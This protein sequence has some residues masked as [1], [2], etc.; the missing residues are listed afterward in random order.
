M[1][2]KP[3][4][5]RVIYAPTALYELDEIWN[6][7]L[8]ANGI[9]QAKAYVTFL[10]GHMDAL[11]V[12]YAGGKTVSVRPDLQF[13]TMRWRKGGHGHIAV[14]QIDLREQTLTIAHVFHT[15]KNWEHILTEERRP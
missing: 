14:Y 10:R 11:S 7:N 5:L 4:T 9:G 3:P 6:W 1:D 13:I 15:R 12:D 2:A 8:D